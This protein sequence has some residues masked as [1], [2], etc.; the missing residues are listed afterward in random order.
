MND[1]EYRRQYADQIAEQRKIN[2]D[3]H[4]ANGTL[5]PVSRKIKRGVEG[6]LAGLILG[7]IL[8]G[9]GRD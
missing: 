9:F 8:R 5:V 2:H 4:K 7:D 3:Y 6:L 1:T